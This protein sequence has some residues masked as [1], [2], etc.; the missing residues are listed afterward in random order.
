MLVAGTVDYMKHLKNVPLKITLIVINIMAIVFFGTSARK[1]YMEDDV[2]EET[3]PETAEP[4]PEDLGYMESVQLDVNNA[5]N[6][7]QN[8]YNNTGIINGIK[9]AAK[10]AV[11]NIADTIKTTG[12]EGLNN[13]K[14]NY[15]TLG[16]DIKN[17]VLGVGEKIR[18]NVSGMGENVSST[19][20]PNTDIAQQINTALKDGKR[21]VISLETDKPPA[22]VSDGVASAP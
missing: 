7:V 8:M 6:Y 4:K 10:N 1:S 20:R 16:Q 14:E 22:P 15:P 3:P 17:T 5:A 12:T 13:I 19:M 9:T 11:T 18:S 2:P 21:L